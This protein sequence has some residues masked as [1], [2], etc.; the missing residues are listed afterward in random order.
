MELGE[1][2]GDEGGALLIDLLL[3]GYRGGGSE[4]RFQ[5]Q[6]AAMWELKSLVGQGTPCSVFG[7]SPMERDRE[8]ERSE[9]IEHAP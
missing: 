2:E 7:S 1:R 9:E 6:H 8:R 3:D 5:P 4:K